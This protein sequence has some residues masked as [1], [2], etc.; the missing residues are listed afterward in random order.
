MLRQSTAF[1]IKTRL[2]RR[3]TRRQISIAQRPLPAVSCNRVSATPPLMVVRVSA[4]QLGVAET[5]VLCDIPM[6]CQV[7]LPLFLFLKVHSS[8]DI[9]LS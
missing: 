1:A 9:F 2:Q 5:S 3:G 4:S 6:K 7:S 8:L